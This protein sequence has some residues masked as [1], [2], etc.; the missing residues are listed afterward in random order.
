MLA[1]D[2]LGHA[3]VGRVGNM[4]M[5]EGMKSK[6]VKGFHGARGRDVGKGDFRLAHEFAE[7]EG[8]AIFPA[9]LSPVKGR[10][11][12]SLADSP[13]WREPVEQLG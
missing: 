5:A 3:R 11:E 1:A 8:Q 13:A 6:I 4:R 10:E 12:R 7:G 9:G 2:F